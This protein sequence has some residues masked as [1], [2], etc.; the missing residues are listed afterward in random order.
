MI[1]SM[2]GFGSAA[3][4]IGNKT[5]QAEIKSVNS[6]F[7]DLSLRLPSAFKDKE[8]E[9]RSELNRL[10]ERGKVECT[11][12]IDSP[13]PVR[14]ASFNVE[15]LADY[16]KDLKALQKK[17]KIKDAPDMMRMLLAM[18]DVMVTEKNG[19][20]ETEWEGLRKAIDEAASAFDS[21]R[22]KEGK[23]LQK[24][25]VNRIHSIQKAMGNLEPF[26]KNRIE[27][28]RKRLRQGL[29]DT[30]QKDEIDRNRF[31]QELIYYLEKLDITEEKVRL[32]SHCEFFL[33][34]MNEELSSGKKL[35]F[36]AQEIGREINTMGSKSNDADMQRIVVEMKDDLEKVKEQVLNVI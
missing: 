3:V 36:I 14:R 17:L 10:I 12:S 7:F 25:L 28:V 31:E 2:T 33:K 24:D 21:F 20:D 32:A 5:I 22:K 29:E 11:V 8:L 18:P 15:L 4:R 1:R 16:H 19:F 35:S 27:S 26:E 30:I 13:G 6:K 9:L 34:T 23:A